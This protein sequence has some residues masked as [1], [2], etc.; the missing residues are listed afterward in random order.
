MPRPKSPPR[1]Y[2]DP[3]RRQWIIRDG[4]SFIRTGCDEGESGPAE[5]FLARYIAAKYKPEPSES[6][7]VADVLN[8][9][10]SEHLPHTM[11][12]AN[13]AYQVEAL[14]NWWGDRNVNQIN[15]ATCREYAKTKSKASARRDLE[16]LRAAVNHWH[17]NHGPLAV[18]P[19]VILPDKHQARTRWLTRSEAA[20]LLWAA[21][22]TEH[23]KRFILLALYT[24]S[25]SGVILGLKWDQIDLSG[26]VLHRTAREARTS[27]KKQAPPV[28]LG[29]RILSHLRRW[30]RLDDGKCEFVCHYDGRRVTKLRRSWSAARKR[31][32]LDASV[33]P[34]VLR[35]TRA[36]WLMQAGIDLWEAAGH[37]GMTVET[38]QAVYG[39][40]H[41]DFQKR[42]AEV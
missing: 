2:L 5:K 8:A 40:H 38:L 20:R 36:T 41:P 4:A 39:K 22:K 28:R 25:R 21:R 1:L 11:A 33:T 12:A 7:L 6:P 13:A 30:Q 14:L 18:V 42:A 23:L 15:A 37:L 10:T 29:R 32:K 26:R 16:T 35:H 31:A 19:T 24:G 34:H 17:R 3:T 9:Y 27:D